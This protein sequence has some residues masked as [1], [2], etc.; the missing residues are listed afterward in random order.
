MDENLFADL[1]L[2]HINSDLDQILNDSLSKERKR[3]L[4]VVDNL[5]DSIRMSEIFKSRETLREKLGIP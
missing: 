3:D 5:N 4:D 2:N 1:E